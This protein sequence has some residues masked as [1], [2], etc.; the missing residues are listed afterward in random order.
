MKTFYEW[1]KE[2]FGKSFMEDCDPELKVLNALELFAHRLGMWL[3]EISKE[4]K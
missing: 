3:N 4:Q 1:H 2:R